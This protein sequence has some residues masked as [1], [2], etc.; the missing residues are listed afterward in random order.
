M[1]SS[2][3]TLG[4]NSS[5]AIVGGRVAS[6]SHPW[7]GGKNRNVI[8]WSWTAG[9]GTRVHKYTDKFKK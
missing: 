1:Y 2:G 9:V 6:G 5:V 4:K 7:E 8:A 3:I